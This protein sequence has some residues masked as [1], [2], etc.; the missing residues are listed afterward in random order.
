LSWRFATV[1]CAFFNLN[2]TL[3]PRRLFNA[4]DL[5]AYLRL[6]LR[7]ADYA[8]RSIALPDLDCFLVYALEPDMLQMCGQYFPEAR[9]THLAAGLLR[10]WQSMASSHDYEVFLNLRHQVAQIAVF[11]RRNLLFYNAFTC[12]KPGDLLYFTL[13]AYDQFKLD[14]ATVPLV[15]AGQMTPDSEHYRL[16]LRYIN[17]IRL[18]IPTAMPPLPDNQWSAHGWVDLCSV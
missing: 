3:V 15:I 5:P 2:S 4:A 1:Q 8:F 16:L 9:V 12:A 6:L 17:H 11:D 10:S 18:A 13:L 7:P 14:T